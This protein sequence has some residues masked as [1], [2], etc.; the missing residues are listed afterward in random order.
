MLGSRDERP[1]TGRDE[2]PVQSSK[3]YA[4]YGN[5]HTETFYA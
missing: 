4:Y 1:A 2:S 3:R 5:I